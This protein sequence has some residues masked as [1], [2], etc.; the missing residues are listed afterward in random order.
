MTAISQQ[1][2]GYMQREQQI[3][4]NKSIG[5]ITKDSSTRPMKQINQIEARAIHAQ[6]APMNYRDHEV[7]ID[8][9]GRVKVFSPDGTFEYLPPHER[10]KYAQLDQAYRDSRDAMHE[11]LRLGT[12]DPTGLREMQKGMATVATVK[13]ALGHD[14]YDELRGLLTQVEQLP[15]MHEPMLVSHR[16]PFFNKPL[17]LDAKIGLGALFVLV[18]STGFNV[19]FMLFIGGVWAIIVG[20]RALH[21]VAPVT[22]NV[23]V[24][25]VGIFILAMLG[26]GRGYDAAAGKQR[27]QD[28]TQPTAPPL[29]KDPELGQ[30]LENLCDIRRQVEELR[31]Q[32]KK[33]AAMPAAVPAE[34]AEQELRLEPARRQSGGRHPHNHGQ[35]PRWIAPSW[36]IRWWSP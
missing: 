8:G 19:K 18:A 36:S 12:V 13:D 27:K 4:Y 23:I 31:A 15:T 24:C 3:R 33:V 20:W 17:S 14:R 32:L 11:C 10:E 16:V 28:M 35:T 29:F 7:A 2:T 26:G 25:I 5:D 22:A 34:I 1:L 30:V 6:D 9:D 21:R